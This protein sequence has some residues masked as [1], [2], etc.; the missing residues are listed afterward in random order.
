MTKIWM[1]YT[2]IA[3]AKSAGT[4][5]ITGNRRLVADMQIWLG[6]SPFANFEKFVA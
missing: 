1:V 2:T 5:V 3:Q 4:L 6:L